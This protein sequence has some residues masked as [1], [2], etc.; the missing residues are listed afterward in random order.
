[1]TDK[2]SYHATSEQLAGSIAT[3]NPEP[4]VI[5]QPNEVSQQL[6]KAPNFEKNFSAM[7]PAPDATGHQA[8]R[9]RRSAS[10]E[11]ILATSF[12]SSTISLGAL[13]NTKTLTDFGAAQTKP[14]TNMRSRRLSTGTLFPTGFTSS[15]PDFSASPEKKNLTDSVIPQA[16]PLASAQIANDAPT[17]AAFENASLYES[18]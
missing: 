13:A 5:R 9:R 1:M 18:K 11:I 7:P 2:E 16:E 17:V 8:I 15:R 10:A 12:T 4:S 14:L 6:L 3:S